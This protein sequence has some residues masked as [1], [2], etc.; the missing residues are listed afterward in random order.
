MP[1]RVGITTNPEQRKRYWENRVT[2]FRNWQLHGYH[3]EKGD[4]QEEENRLFRRCRVH[5]KHR[6]TCHAHHGGGDPDEEGWT[7]YSFDYTHDLGE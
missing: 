5:E 6:G 1:C 7:V 2:E 4:A 3:K